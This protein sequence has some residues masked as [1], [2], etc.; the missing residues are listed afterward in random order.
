MT[1]KVTPV[2]LEVL[3][4][5]YYLRE[6]TKK[7]SPAFVSARNLLILEG[8]IQKEEGTDGSLNNRSGQYPTAVYLATPK[9]EEWVQRILAYANLKQ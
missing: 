6:T 1:I 3:L 7:V 4:E 9:G 8:Y 5:A 2:V